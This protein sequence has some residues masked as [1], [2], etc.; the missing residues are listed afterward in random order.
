M[1][2]MTTGDKNIDYN[3]RR[4]NVAKI[5]KNYTN[6]N[7]LKLCVK[8]CSKSSRKMNNIVWY[9]FDKNTSRSAQMRFEIIL[10]S[11]LNEK[12]I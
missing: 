7:N 8:K 11:F 4:I 12:N 5:I 10:N 2:E 3:Y 6:K 1:L 9:T